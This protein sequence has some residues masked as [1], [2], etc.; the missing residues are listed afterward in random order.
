[1]TGFPIGFKWPEYDIRIVISILLCLLGMKI[2]NKKF[3]ATLVIFFILYEI[4]Y[5]ARTA[6][7]IGK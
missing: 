1:M 7:A 2:N 6:P 5:I 4:V 3:H